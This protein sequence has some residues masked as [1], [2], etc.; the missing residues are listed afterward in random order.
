MSLVG[1]SPPRSLW[2]GGRRTCALNGETASL[3]HRFFTDLK[4]CGV[5]TGRG[6]CSFLFVVRK[7]VALGWDGRRFFL[8][9]GFGKLWRWDG[10]GGRVFILWFGKLWREPKQT[11]AAFSPSRSFR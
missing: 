7:T 5:G 6:S 4:K 10:Y 11:K 9:C 8:V 1:W 3:K 2:C